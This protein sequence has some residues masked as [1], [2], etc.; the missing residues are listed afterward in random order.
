MEL[1]QNLIKAK[2]PCAD[3]YKWFLRNRD[4]GSDYQRLLDALVRADR[5]ADACWL[6]QQFGPTDAVLMLNGLDA[7]A[8]I[9]AGTVIVKG[10]VDVESVIRVGH[11]IRV[12]AGIRAGTAIVAG[13][14]IDCGGNVY[15]GGSIEAGDDIKASWGVEAETRIDCGGMLICTES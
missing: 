15:S 10:S 3:G 14:D 12:G 7:K 13:T 4:G 1:S 2:R 9:F 6:L 8:L 5:V 11:S